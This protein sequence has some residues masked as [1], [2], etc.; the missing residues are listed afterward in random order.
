MKNFASDEVMKEYPAFVIAP[1]CPKDSR[2]VEVHWGL[3]KHDMPKKPS[4]PLSLALAA[5]DSLQEEFSIDE[6]RMYITGLSMGGFWCMGRHPKASQKSLQ[7]QRPSAAAAIPLSRRKL[8]SL[9][10]WAFH[11]DKD[12]AVKV[13]RSREMMEAIKAAGGAPKYTEYK[14]VGHNS[15]SATYANP[16]LYKWMFETGA[17]SSNCRATF[18]E[19]KAT[20]LA[21]SSSIAA[22]Y[23]S[24]YNHT[25]YF[26]YP[27]RLAL[28]AQRP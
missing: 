12:N 27:Q 16:E 19:R 2:W 24:N 21:P 3:D 15:W 17:K 9:P 10:I 4:L 13:H 20:V 7:R 25:L 6:N 8:A 1:Q 23:S 26:P 14:G 11:G 18:A 22:N 28:S 5:V